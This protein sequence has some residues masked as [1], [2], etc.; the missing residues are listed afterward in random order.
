MVSTDIH[1]TG[2]SRALCILPNETAVFAD[3]YSLTLRERWGPQVH[4]IMTLAR[5]VVGV[6]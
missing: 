1:V 4:Q 3:D 2:A 6:N 5:R